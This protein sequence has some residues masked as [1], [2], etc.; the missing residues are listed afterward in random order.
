MN[1]FVLDECPMAAAIYH[2]DVRLPKMVVELYQQL[3]SAV[4]RHGAQ[5]EDMPLTQKGTPL[6][7]GYH[8]HPCTRWVG[9]SISNFMWAHSHAS[10]LLTEYSRRFGKVH[11][12]QKG[13]EKLFSLST[14]I[15]SGELTPRRATR[16]HTGL[17]DAMRG[18]I[19]DTSTIEIVAVFPFTRAGSR[20][21]PIMHPTIILRDEDGD[22]Y[23]LS[24][25]N[26]LWSLLNQVL[27]RYY[28]STV[29]DRLFYGPTHEF[30]ECLA[31]DFKE[32]GDLLVLNLCTADEYEATYK[33]LPMVNT[34]TN[35]N[36]T[37]NIVQAVSSV[38]QDDALT[39]II[40]V[41]RHYK[42]D[43]QFTGTTP[44]TAYNMA[45]TS[46][47]SY[48]DRIRYC[49]QRRHGDYTAHLNITVSPSG[50]MMAE[51]Y[52]KH[53]RFG[54]EIAP[55]D[56]LQ[57]MTE[58]APQYMGPWLQKISEALDN[59]YGHHNPP[60]AK[61]TWE[62]EVNRY[63]GDDSTI[64]SSRRMVWRKKAFDYSYGGPL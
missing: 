16:Q 7:G 6:K 30:I 18:T 33:R 3:G 12:C 20:R 46:A 60:L 44:P 34:K 61:E 14:L 11:A 54:H 40:N 17:V 53:G 22:D 42:V 21:T 49:F 27:G 10:T 32:F 19:I 62:R 8:N 23:V 47:R 45:T 9:D 5:D 29:R 50:S 59:I 51:P 4:R 55:Y 38:S 25:I 15:P 26:V 31:A 28:R 1:I 56:S 64:T 58:Q 52:L 36:D 24:G 63:E 57:K 13:I 39:H 35:A 48:P 43:F 2:D 41:M 37:H